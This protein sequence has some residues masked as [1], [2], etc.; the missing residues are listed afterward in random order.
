MTQ[1][2]VAGPGTLAQFYSSSP[3]LLPS[4]PLGSAPFAWTVR[5][6]VP[7]DV[8]TISTSG[9]RSTR[10]T[11]PAIWADVSGY[12]TSHAA[13]LPASNSLC[14]SE[15]EPG[16]GMNPPTIHL[17]VITTAGSSNEI[18]TLS[19]SPL[20]VASSS[21]M[22]TGGRALQSRARSIES[23]LFPV[24][25]RRSRRRRTFQCRSTSY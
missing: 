3:V 4:A 2:L 5:S 12:L 1:R 10:A 25:S 7:L 15:V 19:G 22:G 14:L 23:T 11:I 9:Q 16:V 8:M 20:R 24:R 18:A 21:T 17:L 6:I 13:L